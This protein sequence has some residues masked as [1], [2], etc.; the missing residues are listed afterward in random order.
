ML[1]YALFAGDDYYPAG[2][3]SDF[4]G[5]YASFEEAVDAGRAHLAAGYGGC[6]Y[7]VVDLSVGS[8][9]AEG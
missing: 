3:W 9:V 1:R 7:H 2:G 5:S 8:V 4:S 6:W